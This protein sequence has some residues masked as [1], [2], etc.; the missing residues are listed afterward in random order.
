MK[1]SLKGNDGVTDNT[2]WQLDTGYNIVHRKFFLIPK[3]KIFM[4]ARPCITES[5]TSAGAL[6]RWEFFITKLCFQVLICPKSVVIRFS[7]ELE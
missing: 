5:F 2:C 3:V 6:P 7:F 1:R 4:D